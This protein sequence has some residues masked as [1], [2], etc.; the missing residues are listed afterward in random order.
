MRM[1][2][3]FFLELFF[4]FLFCIIGCINLPFFQ[5]PPTPLKPSISLKLSKALVTPI[6][7]LCLLNRFLVHI[8]QDIR[9]EE[10]I[11]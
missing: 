1:R 10:E 3:L 5:I 8:A 4:V 2:I 9:K 11:S 7:G 6:L